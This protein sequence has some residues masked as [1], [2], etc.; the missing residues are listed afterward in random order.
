MVERIDIKDLFDISG[1]IAVVT[2]A[3]KG[4]GKGISR[5]LASSGVNLAIIGREVDSL[6]SLKEDLEKMGSTVKYYCFDLTR[7]SAIGDLV[8]EIIDDF[9]KVDILINSAGQNIPKPVEKVTEEDWDS[10]HTV[11]L[12]SVFFIT[13]AVGIHMKKR[14]SGKV[15]NISSQM[16]HVGYFDRTAYGSSK[17]GL[18]QLTRQLSIEWARNGIQVNC[19]APT[20]IKTDMT[21]KMF[22]DPS[23]LNDVLGRIPMNRLGEI[24][25]LLGAV[26]Y[27]ASPSSDFVTGQSIIVD[28]G[29]TVW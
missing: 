8:N 26:I 6:I 21:I 3:T 12:K 19:I 16:A 14:K 7:V 24:D 20:F 4:I 17:G 28:G 23:F 9:G 27:L 22:E 13:Q 25:D 10:I 2:G 5:L 11:N 18:L 15:I 1:K 29:W